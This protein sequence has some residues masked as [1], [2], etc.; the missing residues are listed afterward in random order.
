MQGMWQTDAANS[1]LVFSGGTSMSDFYTKMAQLRSIIF[2][3]QF[4]TEIIKF[5]WFLDKVLLYPSTDYLTIGYL[6]FQIDL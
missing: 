2:L 6:V 5:K 1:R 3:C 4:Q